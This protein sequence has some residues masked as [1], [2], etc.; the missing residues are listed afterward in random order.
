MRIEKLTEIQRTEGSV[1]QP[2]SSVRK[3]IFDDMDEFANVDEHEGIDVNTMQRKMVKGGEEFGFKKC[4]FNDFG[5]ENLVEEEEDTLCNKPHQ[6]F[7]VHTQQIE[8]MLKRSRISLSLDPRKN[9]EIK[10]S[11][12]S[13]RGSLLQPQAQFL[14]SSVSKAY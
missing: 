11:I 5:E 13:V 2:A 1:L 12:I 6:T 8:Q 3:S 14:K 7:M 9:A 10:K 4:K